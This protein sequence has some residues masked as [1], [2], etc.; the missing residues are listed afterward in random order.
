MTDHPPASVS[1][2]WCASATLASSSPFNDIADL[3][4]A[5]KGEW[6]ASWSR[7]SD[8]ERVCYVRRRRVLVNTGTMLKCWRCEAVTRFTLQVVTR[9]ATLR[10]MDQ[11]AWEPEPRYSYRPADNLIGTGG[12]LGA[13]SRPI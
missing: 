8:G 4:R 6:N 13:A 1:A 2:A 7:V 9:I 11:A 5:A 3:H 10:G 12:A